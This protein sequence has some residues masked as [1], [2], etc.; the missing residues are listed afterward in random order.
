MFFKP[1][2]AA[3]VL[4]AL[5]G[6]GI[7]AVSAIWTPSVLSG[8]E[9]AVVFAPG[10][11]SA[12]VP[13]TGLDRPTWLMAASHIDFSGYH[14]GNWSYYENQYRPFLKLTFSRAYDLPVDWRP[15]HVAS[16]GEPDY[17]PEWSDL[18]QPL[19]PE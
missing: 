5:I 9:R 10:L 1:A 6:L 14:C 8:D 15:G 17:C 18:R 12:S 11:G 13:K 16:A 4:G 2:S 19:L 3:F 7:T